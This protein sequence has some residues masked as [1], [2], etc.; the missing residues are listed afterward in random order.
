[1]NVDHLTSTE[2]TRL[3]VLREAYRCGMWPRPYVA[4]FAERHG[5]SLELEQEAEARARCAFYRCTLLRDTG[6]L[7]VR[8]QVTTAYPEPPTADEVLRWLAIGP[9]HLRYASDFEVWGA[10]SVLAAQ[11][12]TDRPFRGLVRTQSSDPTTFYRSV[13]M[14]SHRVFAFLGPAAFQELLASV[15]AE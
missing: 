4:S 12:E 13:V 6:A 5:I 10:L 14:E 2:I 1:M 7:T 3:A 15:D 8:F 11:G 9:A